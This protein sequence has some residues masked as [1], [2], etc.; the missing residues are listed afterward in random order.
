MLFLLA[1]SLPPLVPLL[2]LRSSHRSARELELWTRLYT[3]SPAGT[4]FR[5]FPFAQL[6]RLTDEKHDTHVLY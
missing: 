5:L 1:F 6:L 4:F 2:D 3:H